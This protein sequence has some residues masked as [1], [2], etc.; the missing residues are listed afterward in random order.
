VIVLCCLAAQEW[1]FVGTAFLIRQ[2]IVLISESR[3]QVSNND[4]FSNLFLQLLLFILH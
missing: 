4:W 3:Q 2:R 1:H